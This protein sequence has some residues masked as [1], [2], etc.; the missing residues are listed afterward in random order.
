VTRYDINVWPLLA[1]A[2]TSF[3]NERSAASAI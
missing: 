3:L 2:V 1:T